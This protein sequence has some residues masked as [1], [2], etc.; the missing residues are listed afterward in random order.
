MWLSTQKSLFIL[1]SYSIAGQLDSISYDKY[2]AAIFRVK[3]LIHKLERPQQES[4]LLWKSRNCTWTISLVGRG[5]G[6]VVPVLNSLCTIPCKCVQSQSH[7]S[8]Q[9]VWL[10][11]MEENGQLHML[12]ISFP[13]TN[14][15]QYPVGMRLNACTPLSWVQ[16]Q[17]RKFLPLPWMK[18]CLCS[19]QCNHYI[20]LSHH[21]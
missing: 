7:S 12:A 19:A 1:R 13:G 20:K 2:T 4:L 17:R 8:M 18:P 15:Y 14:P 21:M 16:W 3:D 9:S 10:C 6:L 5:T 11:W